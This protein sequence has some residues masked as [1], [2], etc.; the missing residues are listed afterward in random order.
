[1]S[2]LAKMAHLLGGE[3]R[4][5]EVLCPGPGHSS[6]DRSLAVKPDGSG[7]FIC[8]SFANDDLNECRDHIRQKLG[9]PPFEAKGNGGG[10]AWT[11]IREHVYKTADGVPHVR[12]RKMLDGEGKRQFPQ[13]YWDGKQWIKGIPKDWPRLLYKLPELLNSSATNIIYVTEGEGDADVLCAMN[14]T[15]T[16]AGGVTSKWTPEMIAFLKDRRAVIFVDAD[17][18]GRAYG[19]K[20]AA[21]IDKTA[22]TVKVVDLFP[23][24]S[25]GADVTDFIGS[26]RAGVKLLKAVN[27]TPDW[28]PSAGKDDDAVGDDALIAELAALPV[29]EYE[30][31]REPAAEQLGVRV[32]VL[33]K[34]VVAERVKLVG[35]D[36]K[37]GHA[38]TLP[39]PE[40]WPEA[41]NG[42]E[43]LAEVSG[44]IK[45]YVVLVD[46]ACAAV[47]LWIVHT[48]LLDCFQITPRLAI[49]S[50]MHRC[51]KTTLLD[52]VSHMVTRPLSTANVTASAI[53][54]VVEGYRPTLLIDEAD[55]FL[56]E[57]EEL[58]GVVN[59]GHRQGGA[60]VR[61]VGDEH[62]PRRFSTYGACAIALIGKLP[63]TLHDRSVTVDLKRRLASEP[64]TSFRSDRTGDLDMLA[65]KVARWAVDNVEKV[66]T[67]DPEMPG[68]LF[69]R[70]ADNWQPLLAIATVAGGDWAER[71][72]K[73]L[74]CAALPQATMTTSGWRCWYPTLTRSS[75]TESRV[76]RRHY[77]R[78]TW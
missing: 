54:R 69:N 1:M 72:R 43:L 45:R 20:V 57:N 4:G 49:R 60:V 5:N 21:A 76:N 10:K 7:G 19:E 27:E 35:D 3:V 68:T 70:D 51:G 63:A 66:R 48:Y 56:P 40:L 42:A 53:F 71:A 61:T 23:D 22:K 41:V 75:E 31:R 37:A 62:E 77:L 6:E 36:G 13:D 2:A 28:E 29:L 18:Q 17:K 25:D 26:D 58:R 78:S 30:R 47:A 11:L 8:H 46:H 64:V 16:T 32:S 74:S 59:S 9:L 55:S 34:L 67:T 12:K 73:V 38:L 33:D 50:P 14:L 44:A 24:R 15:A 39:E 52:V 65:R